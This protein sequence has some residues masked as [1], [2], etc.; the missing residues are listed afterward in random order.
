MK[1]SFL[2]AALLITMGSCQTKTK[3]ETTTQATETQPDSAAMLAKRPGPDSPRSA[4]DRLV[5]ALYFEHNKKD[6]PFRDKD[7]ALVEQFFEKSLAGQITAALSSGK[8]K[9]TTVNPLFNAPDKAIKKAWV[10][11]AAVG[12]TRA[13]VYVTFENN[14][15]PEEI[16]VDMQQFAGR[17][18]IIEMR[19]P[20]EK[21]LTDMV[22]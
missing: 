4:A 10:D 9:A 13:I 3:Q 19:Y 12:G 1:A 16:K 11:P 21:K 17:W 15:K 5:R 20:D 6:N 7:P 2:V 14:A 22:K 8:L 18:R